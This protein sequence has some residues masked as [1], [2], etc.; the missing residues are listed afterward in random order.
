V[1]LRR[2]DEL[3]LS[4]SRSFEV[5]SSIAMVFM[6]L[7]IPASLD[8]AQGCGSLCVLGC[9]SLWPYLSGFIGGMIE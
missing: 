4:S 7:I 6:R 3:S 5:A 8:G 2:R 9:G 1:R